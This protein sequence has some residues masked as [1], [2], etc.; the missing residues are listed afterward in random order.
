MRKV[1]QIINELETNEKRYNE[2]DYLRGYIDAIKWVLRVN[3]P[4]YDELSGINENYK[5]G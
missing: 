2:S 3:P 4:R 5:K 1:E